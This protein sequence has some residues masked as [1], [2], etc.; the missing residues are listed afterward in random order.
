MQSLSPFF[1]ERDSLVPCFVFQLLIMRITNVSG[2]LHR[3]HLRLLLQSLERRAFFGYDGQNLTKEEKQE[4]IKY[5]SDWIK[6]LWI[7]VLALSGGL[8]SLLLKLDSH[9]KIL[10]LAVGLILDFA[11]GIFIVLLH[12]RI[13]LLMKELGGAK[14]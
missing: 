12:Q 14:E 2:H 3:F 7:G 8:A 5:Y 13:E 4:R 1:I 6:S 11:L 9:P 10:L